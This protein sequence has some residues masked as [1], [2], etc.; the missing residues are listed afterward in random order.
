MVRLHKQAQG[1]Q[2]MKKIKQFNESIAVYFDKE[3]DVYKVVVDGRPDATSEEDDKQDA[4][5]T[6]EA[7]VKHMAET[8]EAYEPEA[9][10]KMS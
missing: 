10:P 3:W 6:A 7:M 9:L 4:F 1:V 2:H 8:P 5:D